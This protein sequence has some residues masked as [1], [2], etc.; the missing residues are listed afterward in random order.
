MA[1]KTRIVRIDSTAPV[2]QASVSGTAGTNNW[3]LSAVQVSLSATDNFS[4]VL[5]SFY[6][7]NGGAEQPYTGPFVIS[8]SGTHTVE[9]WSI[10]N[11]NNR[12]VVRSLIVKIDP[13]APVVTAASSPTSASKSPRPV[14]VTISGNASD[15]VSGV[16][17][18][19]FNVIDEY[20][21]TQPAGEGTLQANGNYSFTVTLPAT[22]NGP[23]K[24]G[25][26]YTI[27]VRTVDQAGN[28]ATAT[29]TLRIN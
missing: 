12:E 21:V 27:V 17:S 7:I 14:T 2:T 9:Y 26:L 4:G 13:V 29:A 8:A 19:S 11:L 23:D 16:S 25:H 6:R 3:Y 10:D 24:D 20:G 28:S 1:H 15:A 22:R 18:A 5:G